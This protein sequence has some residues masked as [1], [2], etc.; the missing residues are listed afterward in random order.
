MV[1]EIV[2]RRLTNEKI[3]NFLK[4]QYIKVKPKR[5]V[6]ILLTRLP[7]TLPKEAESSVLAK[8]PMSIIA[9]T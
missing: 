8:D 1:T 6:N 9:K 7:L 4:G 3:D 2:I 5:R